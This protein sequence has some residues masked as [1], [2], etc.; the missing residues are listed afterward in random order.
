MA[1]AVQ[2]RKTVVEWL[3]QEGL[4][5]GTAPNPM[6]LGVCSR[7]KDVIEPVLKPQWY[8]DCKGMAEQAC[9]AVRD[10][11]IN[12][13]PA[14]Y[15]ATWFRWVLLSQ[16]QVFPPLSRTGKHMQRDDGYGLLPLSS[17]S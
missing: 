13:L 14:E 6:R 9:D 11:R 7:S 8:V 16:A 12:I 10:G 4:Y 3:K 15:Q 17:F 1:V 5:R 2:A